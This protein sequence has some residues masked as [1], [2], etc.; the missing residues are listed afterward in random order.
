MLIVGLATVLAMTVALV[1][2]ASAAYLQRQGLDTL[3]DGAALRGADLG[4]TG[5]DVY[6]GGVPD[7]RLELTAGRARAAVADYLR[8]VGAYASYPGLSFSVSVDPGANSVQVRITA[9]LDLPLHDPRL[10]GAGHDRRL[11]V[12]GGR[13]RVMSLVHQVDQTHDPARSPTY[14]GAMPTLRSR[15]IGVAVAV[16]L[17]LTLGTAAP[18]EAGRTPAGRYANQAHKATNNARASQDMKALRKN[19]CLKRFAVRQAKRMAN[20]NTMYHQDL[21]PIMDACKLNTAGENVAYGYPTGRSVVW[22][23]WM[24]SEGHRANILSSSYRIMGIGARK[25]SDGRWYV[26]QVFGRKA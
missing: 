11:R 16:T 20:Q 10:A 1:V 9:P 7:E 22:D 26:A 12:G 25:G 15:A 4:A 2:D 8:D 19:D 3:A 13:R 18:A 21:G 5:V 23:G 24:H 14:R 17:G 6:A